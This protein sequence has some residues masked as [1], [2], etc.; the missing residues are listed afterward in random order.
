[1]GNTSAKNID[2]SQI[3]LYQAFDIPKDFTWDQLKNAYKKAALQ[4]HPDKTNGNR[5]LFNFVTNSFEKLAIE[6][7]NR[8]S[9][10]SHQDLKKHSQEY[11]ENIHSKTVKQHENDFADSQPFSTRFNKAF[12]QYKYHDENIENGYGDIMTKSNDVREEI[13]IENLF[14]KKRVDN[15]TFN[16]LFNKKIPISKQITKYQEPAPLLM[17]KKLQFTDIVSNKSDDYTGETES[18]S[19]SFTDYMKAHSGERLADPNTS[20]KEYNSVKEYQRYREKKTKSTL[21]DKEKRR[22]EK[23]TDLEKQQ[24]QLRLE[25][26]Q[27]Q[28]LA[29]QKA[30]EKANQFLI[31]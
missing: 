1:M 2:L 15:S 21:S 11:Y 30:H 14:A 7:K 4:T 29:I 9:N 6:Y 28:D 5:E 12:D 17:A 23:K 3:D 18:K 20:F 16:E 19:L 22:L 10:K 24:E 8:E 27:Q 31:R 13:T 26:L 25:K